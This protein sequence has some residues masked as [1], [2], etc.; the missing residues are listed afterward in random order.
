MPNE[1]FSPRDLELIKP[2]ML[3]ALFGCG[4]LLTD[5]LHD[6]R[7]K[8]WN[9]ITALVGLGFT[10]VQL[11]LIQRAMSAVGYFDPGM[12]GNGASGFHGAIVVDAFSL[13]FNWIFLVAAAISILF[14]VRYLDIE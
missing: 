3:L 4:I 9:A 11:Y 8:Y 10:G 2:A 5:L 13:Y 12:A 7:H 1:F 14:S 6:E